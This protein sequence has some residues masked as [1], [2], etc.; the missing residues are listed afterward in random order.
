MAGDEPCA[1][2]AEVRPSEEVVVMGPLLTTKLQIPRRR[3]GLV[4]RRRLSERLKRGSEAVLT[5]VSAPAGFGKTTLLTEW[6]ACTDGSTVWLSLDERDNDPVVFWTY[7]ITALR[8][9]TGEAGSGALALLQ[10]PHASLD[11]VL[12]TLVNELDAVPDDVILVLDDYH[13]VTARE[14]NERVA[15]L[16]EHLPQ[17]IHLVIATRADPALPLARLRARGELVEVRADDLRFTAEEVAT[18]LDGAMGP[19]LT[20]EHVAALEARTEGW[21][22][23]LQLAVLSMQGRDDVAGFIAGFA[24]DDRYIVDYLVEEVLQRQPGDVRTFLLQT[25]V[26]HRLSGPLCDAVTGRDGG[27]AMLEALDRANLFLVPLDDRRHWYRYHHLFADVLHARLLAE[28][29]DRVPELHRRASAWYEQSDEPSEAIHHALAA[30][31]HARAADLVELA[32]PSLVQARQEATLRNWMRALPVE[33]FATRPVLSVGY[34]GALMSTGDVEGV[35]ARLQDAERCLATTGAPAADV[36]VVDDLAFRRLPGQIAMYRAGQALISGEVAASM[37][38]ARRALTLAGPD[39]HLGRGGPSALLGLA[40]WTAGDLES[41]YRWYADGMAALAE[42]GYG[43]DVIGGAITLADILIVQGRLR[44]ALSLYQ[45]G[46]ARA[47]ETAPPLRGAADMHV[48]MSELLVERDD[49]DAAENHLRR[50]Q[51]LGEHAGLPK[52][53]YRRRVAMARIQQL[54]GDVDGA[55]A[56]L[57]EAER[58]Y[59]SDYSPDVRPIPAVRA[60]TFL[61]GDRLGEALDWARQRGLSADDDLDYVRE[62]EHITLA[63]VLLARWSAERQGVSLREATA[64]LQ[65]LLRAAEEGKRTGSVIEILMLQALAAQARGDVTAAL[66]PVERALALAEPEGYVRTFVDE[67]PQLATLLKALAEDGR[68]GAYAARLGAALTPGNEGIPLQRGLVEPLSVRELEV[69]RLLGTD[70]DG[71]AIARRLFL[72]L[73]TVRTH[74]R[75]IY[76]KLGVNSRRAAV[77][78]ATDLDLLSALRG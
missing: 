32:I 14:V 55:L 46:L 43:P 9:A 16:L 6:L 71:P 78:R 63:R 18:Y 25:S 4:P 64:L 51:E 3:R 21:I 29:P 40:Y 28:Q 49:L 44:D 77:R 39:D 58:W 23:A 30:R 1:D 35:E 5:L 2:G 10:E 53:P 70:L 36:V 54:H 13:V 67:G 48:G 74:T 72:S 12:A 8:T 42:G 69:L 68:A 60:R 11:Q 76:A 22:A 20:A 33:L 34:V 56:L 47:E 19:A 45:R 73:N 59:N 31:D 41:A 24:G 27:T 15:F 52:N 37:T 65:R 7:L 38:H 66:G 62:F 57:D 75:N 61:A 17:N 50:S 26:L